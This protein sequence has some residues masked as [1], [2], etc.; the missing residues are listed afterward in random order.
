MIKD[1]QTDQGGCPE[2]VW[3]TDG[4][5]DQAGLGVL[6]G[7]SGLGMGMAG[8][9]EG[10]WLRDGQTDQAGLSVLKGVLVI[11]DGQTDQAGEVWVSWVRDGQV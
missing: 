7:R 6:G 1:G 10:L 4:Q 3:V 11:K 2:G 8:C 5:T 9:P